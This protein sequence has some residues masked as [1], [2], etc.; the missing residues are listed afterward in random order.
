ML[1]AQTCCTKF[2]ILNILCLG[3][4][5]HAKLFKMSRSDILDLE[6]FSLKATTA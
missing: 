5:G 6:I 2:R 3:L 1:L 4:P